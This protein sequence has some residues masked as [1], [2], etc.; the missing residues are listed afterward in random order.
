MTDFFLKVWNW[1][2]VDILEVNSSNWRFFLFLWLLKIWKFWLIFNGNYFQKWNQVPGDGG[3]P[4]VRLSPR[5]KN[6]LGKTLGP[7]PKFRKKR[8]FSARGISWEIQGVFKKINICPHLNFFFT[9]K[10]LRSISEPSFKC[11]IS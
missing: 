1:I 2:I 6:S 8:K 10:F 4:G 9:K 3:Q 5:K 7:R 11:I